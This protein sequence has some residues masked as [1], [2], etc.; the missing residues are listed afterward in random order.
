MPSDCFHEISLTYSSEIIEKALHFSDE[1]ALAFRLADNESIILR[2]VI[3]E[4]VT[5]MCQHGKITIDDSISFEVALKGNYLFL[6]AVDSGLPF[7]PTKDLKMQNLKKPVD[8][9]LTGGLGWTMI[10]NYFEIHGY[11]YENQ[12][13]RLLLQ[14]YMSSMKD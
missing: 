3:E 7:D 9:R 12:Q 8:Q 5:N 13:N 2:L 4:L 11:S 6:Q 1:C 14:R 10:K